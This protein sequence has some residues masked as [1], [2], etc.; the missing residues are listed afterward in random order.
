MATVADKLPKVGRVRLVGPGPALVLE[1]D[2]T[3]ARAWLPPSDLDRL[4]LGE[5][6]RLYRIAEDGAAVPAGHAVEAPSGAAF[7]VVICG[8]PY[9]AIAAQVRHALR[10]GCRAAL[11]RA[12]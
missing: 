3:G 12:D 6:A 11:F 9:L 1:D 5:V 8:R 4:R 10:V 2:E 7:H